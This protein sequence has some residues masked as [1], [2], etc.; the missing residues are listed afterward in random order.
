MIQVIK[1]DRY[2]LGI[3]EKKRGT[4]DDQEQRQENGSKQVDMGD[5]VQCQS[6]HPGLRLIPEF[7]GHPTVG[8]LMKHNGH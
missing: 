7:K 1:V 2:R 3:T 8:H 6:P 4:S 5:R